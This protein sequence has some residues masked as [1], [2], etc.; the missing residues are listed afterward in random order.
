MCTV[1]QNRQKN[2]KSNKNT[3]NNKG[4]ASRIWFF[5]LGT[6]NRQFCSDIILKQFV[7]LWYEPFNRNKNLTQILRRITTNKALKCNIGTFKKNDVSLPSLNSSK[8]TAYSKVMKKLS[9][10]RCI[11]RRQLKIV[12]FEFSDSPLSVSELPE[13]N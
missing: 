6:S 9:V 13:S 4:L 7:A 2:L 1:F 5:N 3:M 12:N 10:S 8:A 11:A